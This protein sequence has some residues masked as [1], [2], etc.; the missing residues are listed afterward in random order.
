MN[1]AIEKLEKGEPATCLFHAK[2]LDM[3]RLY[4]EK[5]YQVWPVE[6]RVKDR[7]MTLTP[8]EPFVKREI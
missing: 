1:W 8:V 6:I 5:T 4:L 3:I 2:L 7:M